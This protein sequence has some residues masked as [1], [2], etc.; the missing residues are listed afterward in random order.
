MQLSEI[1]TLT[2]AGSRP[3]EIHDIFT[4]FQNPRNQLRAFNVK[5]NTNDLVWHGVPFKSDDEEE[6]TVLK[7]VEETAEN[8]LKDEQFDGPEI[9]IEVQP[10]TIDGV[11]YDPDWMVYNAKI[12]EI[13]M[14]M[15]GYSPKDNAFYVGFDVWLSEDSFNEAWEEFFRKETDMEFDSDDHEHREVF[16]RAWQEYLKTPFTGALVKV[17][18]NNGA[19]V[20]EEEYIV[21]GGYH[22]G[23]A[24]RVSQLHLITD[25]E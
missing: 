8:F 16:N 21:D 15:I 11:D 18:R 5:K 6:E 7:L 17:Y 4:K 24:P 25:F 14:E 20:A 1:T 2:E 12:A 10:F 9:S 19:L 22:K 13:Q 23:V 3:V